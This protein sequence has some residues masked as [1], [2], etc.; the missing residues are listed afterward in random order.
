[1]AHHKVY[2]PEVSF[3]VLCPNG[4]YATTVTLKNVGID[5]CRFQI[6]CPRNSDGVS[7]GLHSETNFVSCQLIQINN[8]IQTCQIHNL[9]R[10]KFNNCFFINS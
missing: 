4:T 8:F 7:V 2:P 3:G 10:L 9:I 1:M 5:S 6:K